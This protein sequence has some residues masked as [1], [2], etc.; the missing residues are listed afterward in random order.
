M[1]MLRDKRTGLLGRKFRALPEPARRKFLAEHFHGVPDY[2]SLDF[3]T[4]AFDISEWY[5]SPLDMAKA[6]DWIYRHT[7]T[8]DAAHSMR[9]ILA[10]ET[11]L[12]HRAAIWKYV[13]FKGGSEDQ[14]LAGNWLLED[15]SGK[16]YTLDVFWNSSQA[17][18][19]PPQ[20]LEA[21]DK[22]LTL[23]E[24]RLSAEPK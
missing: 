12:P 1:T 22:I 19:K 13:G 20:F 8:D 17:A 4:A 6:L 21:I 18:V 16:W 2:E 3:D 15:T 7:R 14:L 9:E 5:A 10:V 23:I 24:R 11:K